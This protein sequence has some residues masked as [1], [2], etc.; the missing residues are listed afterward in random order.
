M[1]PEIDKWLAAPIRSL[2][3]HYVIYYVIIILTKFPG[4][5]FHEKWSSWLGLGLGGPRERHARDTNLW[6]QA[7]RGRGL[8]SRH[9]C[10]I[11]IPSNSHAR[12]SR[13][14]EFV[15]HMNDTANI[16]FNW[17]SLPQIDFEPVTVFPISPA[18]LGVT[19]I[20]AWYRACDWFGSNCG[21]L[22]MVLFS[23]WGHLRQSQV[24]ATSRL[25]PN[26]FSLSEW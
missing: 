14:T 6:T 24:P 12:H 2:A 18:C 13:L 26:L 20:A 7:A 21:E 8:R 10:M 1:L 22:V 19:V 11:L 5:N 4:Y 15:I 17:P 9:W 16:L 3:Q 23:V 25:F